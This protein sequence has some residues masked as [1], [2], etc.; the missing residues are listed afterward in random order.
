MRTYDTLISI[1]KS[2]DRLCCCCHYSKS[3]KLPF[4]LSESCSSSI[5][6]KVWCDLCGPSPISCFLDFIFYAIFVGDYCIN[7]S[8]RKY[9][10]CKQVIKD[11]HNIASTRILPL[12]NIKINMVISKPI[13]SNNGNRM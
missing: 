7:K 2:T 5:L 1:N 11:E 3:K 4:T 6:Q 8:G 9:M 13:Q 10:Y 12:L